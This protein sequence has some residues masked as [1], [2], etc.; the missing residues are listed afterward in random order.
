MITGLNHIT[1]SVSNLE[2][3]IDFY[4]QLGFTGHVK[5]QSGAYLSAGDLW[6]CLALGQSAPA[7][8]YSHIAFTIANEHF[9]SFCSRMR[10]MNIAEWKSNSS[11]GDSIYLLD[12]DGHQLEVHVGNLD[13]RLKSLEVQPY[14]GLE[15]L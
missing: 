13:S 12:P 11:E 9:K 10:Q 5:W 6:L 7:N 1:L 4:T 15:W 8:D 3:S 2:R 14:D